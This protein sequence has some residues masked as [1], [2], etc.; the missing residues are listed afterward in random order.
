MVLGNSST[1]FVISPYACVHKIELRSELLTRQV[2][3]GITDIVHLIAIFENFVRP[4][5]DFVRRNF[6][7][8]KF[9]LRTDNF[10]GLTNLQVKKF[11]VEVGLVAFK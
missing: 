6:I 8:F 10:L 1:S 9:S 7:G 2:G 4:K 3:G 5:F 11:L